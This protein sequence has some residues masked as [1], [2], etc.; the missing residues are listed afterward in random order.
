M[1]YLGARPGI[2]ALD[3]GCGTGFLAR[4][5]ARTLGDVQAVGLEADE[6]MLDLARHMLEREKLPHQVKVW[7]G[8]A[9]QLPFP[10][11]TFD[12]VTSHTVL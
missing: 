6:K 3:V 12:L 7:Q 8:D 10:D 9:Y 2:R 11:Q 5:L 1:D 4:L